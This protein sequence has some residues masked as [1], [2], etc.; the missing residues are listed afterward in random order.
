M[1]VH[2]QEKTMNQTNELDLIWIINVLWRRKWLIISLVLLALVVSIVVLNNLPPVYKATTTI[3]IEQSKS[4][5]LSEYSMLM[6]AERLALTYSQIITSRPILEQVIF[7]LNLK[8]TVEKLEDK[9]TVQP[10][11]DTQL[12]KITVTNSSPYQVF[13]IAN[14]IAETFIEYIDALSAENYAQALR[15]VQ[16]S[17]DQ[18]QNEIDAI[19]PEIDLQNQAKA[20]LEAEINRLESLLSDNRTSLLTL[21]ENVRSLELII[22][23]L[24]NKIRV[25][26]PAHID[27]PTA[28]RDYNA[29][30]ILFFEQD[31]VS[32]ST[33]YSGQVSDLIL[34]IYGPMLERDAFL[35]EV[36]DRLDLDLSP[37]LLGA[38]IS[39]TTI[40]DTQFLQVNV[41]DDDPSQAILIADTVAEV[42]IDQ[43]LAALNQPYSNRL[44]NLETDISEVTAQIEL[45]QEEMNSNNSMIIPID[46]ELDRLE[47]E[48]S[49]KYSD[50]RELQTSHDQYIFDAKRSA[51]TIVITEPATQPNSQSQNSILYIGLSAVVA[52]ALGAGLTFLLEQLEDRVRTQEDIAK[53][54]DQKPI[55]VVGHMEKGKDKLILGPNS[56]PFVAEDFRKLSAVIR[57]AIE[58]VPLQK[59]LVTSPNPGEGK[60]TVAANLAIVLAKTGNQVILVDADLHRPQVEFLFNLNPEIGLSEYLSSNIK[61]APLKTTSYQNLQ[62]LSSGESPDDASELLSSTKLGYILENLASKADLVII[63]SPPLLTLADA[64]FLT[65]LV[66]GVLLVINSGSTERKAAVE[67]MALLKMAKIQFVGIVLNG[68]TTRSHSYYRYY[69]QEH[70]KPEKVTLE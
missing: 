16:L 65:P 52:C 34:Q 36:I 62:V 69:D 21:Q 40:P 4:G 22:S 8:T 28:N 49:T 9:I 56:S 48:L 59:L 68:V 43:N 27:N 15:D 54:L 38:K 61:I 7:D 53:L 37:A 39:Y 19:L 6:A 11:S 64:S 3:L 50:L 58:G 23:Q 66:D 60:S 44:T 20:D 12:I 51:N 17:M 47:R 32:A 10:V 67:A 41:S 33:N 30:L 5:T 2:P 1:S 25:I 24:N 31:L 63:D 70:K 46:L 57:Q 35:V 42:F 45:I 55:G 14:S 13:M 29:S 26:E 18:K